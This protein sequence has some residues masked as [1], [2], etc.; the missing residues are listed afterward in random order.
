MKSTKLTNKNF[1]LVVVGQ[2][3]SLFGNGILRFALPLHLL[4]ITG[5]SAIFGVV[6]AVSFLPLVVL[7][8]VGGII[9]DRA[10]KRNIMVTLDFITGLLMLFFYITMNSVSL[11]PLIVV[12]LII[13]F[14][15]SGLYQPTVQASI[16]MLLDEK[17]LV[18]GNGIVSSI[19]GLSNLISPFIGGILL[20]NYGIIPIVMVSFICFFASAILELFI[21]IPYKKIITSTTMID[22]VKSDMRVS[23]NFIFK[24]KPTLKK[25]MFVTC[26]LNAFISALIIISLAVLITERLNLSKEMYGYTLSALALGGL[27]G[28]IIAGVLSRKIN[29]IKLPICFALISISLIPMSAAMYIENAYI[30]SYVLIMISAFLVMCISTIASVII[31]TYIQAETPENMVGKI[32]AF[33]M[34]A[35][36]FASPIGQALYGLAFEY[37]IGHESFVILGAIVITLFISL[38]TKRV[39][40]R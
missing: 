15:I 36:M 37:F 6:S 2:I 30:I 17:I 28:G 31:I 21:K 34:T 40:N 39:V 16:P 7:M 4:D 24:E 1:V 3:I 19:S 27:V 23:V 22:M 33:V 9:A 8:P 32:M 14:S 35:S 38:F 12:A 29:I 25:L 11:I 13:L 20:T 10:N 26:M 18:S 5:S